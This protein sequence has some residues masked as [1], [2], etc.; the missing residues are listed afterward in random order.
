AAQ[1][2]EDVVASLALGPGHVHLGAVVEVPQ[3]LRAG[4]VVDEPVE[5]RE[6]RRA[7]GNPAVDGVGVRDPTALLEPHAERAEAL[8]LP[9]RLRLA[10]G[11]ALRL[12]ID[13]LGE[14]PDAL[15]PAAA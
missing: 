14:V 9:E 6:E 1:D 13:A 5:G 7:R 4:A 11:H 10:Q 8:L 2:R 15:L 12:R 3:R